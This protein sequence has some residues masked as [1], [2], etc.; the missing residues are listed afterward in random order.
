MSDT[1]NLTLDVTAE[2]NFSKVSIF[3]LP[4]ILVFK[5]L[6]LSMGFQDNYFELFSLVSPAFISEPPHLC[7]LSDD[8]LL[9]DPMTGSVIAPG[10]SDPALNQ[11]NMV[12]NGNQNGT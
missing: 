1:A 3:Y 9:I 11:C 7:D 12:C 10:G 2:I 6:L 5:A 4:R 8:R